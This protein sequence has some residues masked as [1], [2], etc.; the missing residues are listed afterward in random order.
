MVANNVIYRQIIAQKGPGNLNVKIVFAF[1][2][3]L[4]IILVC[5]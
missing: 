5:R 1:R 2:L 4:F 3:E